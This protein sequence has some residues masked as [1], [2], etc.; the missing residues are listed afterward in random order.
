MQIRNSINCDVI[1]LINHY[2]FI[3]EPMN[4][5]EFLYFDKGNISHTY[6]VCKTFCNAETKSLMAYFM[7][8]KKTYN[9]FYV[10]LSFN[11]DIKVQQIWGEQMAIMSFLA[12]LP[13]EFEI[14]KS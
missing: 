8:F 3:K 6:N 9:E 2:E 11:G 14:L 4:Y 5:L 10:F 1:G 12:D 7:K 13:F